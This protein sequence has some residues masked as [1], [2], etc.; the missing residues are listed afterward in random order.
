MTGITGSIESLRVNTDKFLDYLKF[1]YS[2]FTSDDCLSVAASLSYT[3]LLSLVPLMAVMFSTLAAFPIFEGLESD[4]EAFVFN[5]FVPALGETV[6]TYLHQFSEKASGLRLAGLIFLFITVLAMMNTIEVAFNRIWR[7]R[8][9]RKP[10]IRFLA[11]WAILT[12]GPLLVGFGFLATSYLVSLPLFSDVDQ[13]LEVKRRSL[14]LLPFVS[15]T[16]A[17]VLIYK[18][19]PNRMVALKSA[20]IGAIV[21]ATLFELAKRAFAYYVTHFPSQQAIYGAFATIPIFLLWIYLSWVIVLL[22]AEITRCHMSYRRY[23]EKSKNPSGNLF[24]DTFRIIGQIWRGQ[25]TGKPCSFSELLM[26]E[27]TMNDERIGEII[28]NLR[29]IGWL[30]RSE[31]GSWI[32]MRDLDGETLLSLYTALPGG[33]PLSGGELS[34]NDIWEQQLHAELGKALESMKLS[35]NSS[36]KSLYEKTG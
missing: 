28:R 21:A 17:F 24:I 4:I 19:L 33:L 29:E 25:N 8:I 14:I 6:Q 34:S 22:G 2:H 23:I 9:K 32:L 26:L 15:S 30:Q 10:M 18:L 36:L 5:N 11:Y 35:M 12:L 20:L 1:V 31:E 7:V 16:L 13:S 3:T 27:P